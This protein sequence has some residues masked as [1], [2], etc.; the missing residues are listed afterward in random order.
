MAICAIFTQSIT[1]KSIL[2]SSIGEQQNSGSIWQDTWQQLLRWRQKS[3]NASMM[4]PSFTFSGESSMFCFLIPICL[5]ICL[6]MPT[7]LHALYQHITAVF[8]DH[9]PYGQIKNIMAIV[10]YPWRLL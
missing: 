6:V 5:I 4:S 8:L 7:S 1:A 10:L 9:R 2:L 3:S